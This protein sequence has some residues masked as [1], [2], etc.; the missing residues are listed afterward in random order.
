MGNLVITEKLILEEAIKT[1]P[2]VFKNEG[3]ACFMRG[4]NG[5]GTV[6]LVYQ[7]PNPLPTSSNMLYAITELDGV[8]SSEKLADD[9]GILLNGATLVS[10]VEK[11]SK[12]IF[13]ISNCPGSES[14]VLL[15]G[16]KVSAILASMYVRDLFSKK[17]NTNVTKL[18]DNLFVSVDSSIVILRADKSKQEH[19]TIATE[20]PYVNTEAIN[21][22]LEYI[23]RHDLLITTDI[24]LN[25]EEKENETMT[26]ETTT[27]TEATPVVPS[28]V[29]CSNTGK[30]SKGEPCPICSSQEKPKVKRTRKPVDNVAVETIL[31]VVTPAAVIE[32][33][34]P[35]AKEEDKPVVKKRRSPEEVLKD[36]I[37]AAV[38]LLSDN[39]Y[40]VDKK[41]SEAEAKP[42]ELTEQIAIQMNM[43]A[44]VTGNLKSILKQVK[45]MQKNS[46]KSAI[47]P[48]LKKALEDLLAKS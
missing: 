1:L 34:A 8:V 3:N 15:A 47:D 4:F 14:D 42:L 23:D 27:V 21:F 31:P 2:A 25:T 11:S 17:R 35:P 45:E 6:Q 38:K 20:L 28:C 33:A 26:T 37:D 7:V 32:Q 44:D 48:N 40:N 22:V 39:G 10:A 46:H 13:E 36:S 16:E 18:S 29:A 9:N 5:E 30:N 19:W 41:V 43:L 12:S 24:Q